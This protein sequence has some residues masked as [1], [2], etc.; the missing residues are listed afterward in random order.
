M[1]MQFDITFYYKIAVIFLLY[2]AMTINNTNYTETML[3][4]KMREM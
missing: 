2:Q 3:T 1:M 4:S